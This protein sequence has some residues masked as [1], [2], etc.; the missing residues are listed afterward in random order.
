MTAFAPPTMWCPRCEREDDLWQRKD[1]VD[2]DG[3]KRYVW[4]HRRCGYRRAVKDGRILV[5]R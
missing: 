2:V 4:K 3:E 5:A 1:P